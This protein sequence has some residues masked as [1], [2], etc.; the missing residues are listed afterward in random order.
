MKGIVL[1]LKRIENEGRRSSNMEE[2]KYIILDPIFA[3]EKIRDLI[4]DA[5][6]LKGM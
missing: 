4:Q 1:A 6:T 3:D 5:R 2:K